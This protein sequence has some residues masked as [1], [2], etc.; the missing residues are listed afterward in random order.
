MDEEANYLKEKQFFL[1]H[2][3]YALFLLCIDDIESLLELNDSLI[4]QTVYS[5]F[6][7]KLIEFYLQLL[8]YLY[9]TEHKI[10]K[11]MYKVKFFSII[12]SISL[13]RNDLNK[14][15]NS[16]LRIIQLSFINFK[17]NNAN[18]FCNQIIENNDMELLIKEIAT[19]SY[20]T[21]FWLSLIYTHLYKLEQVLKLNNENGLQVNLAKNLGIHHEIRRLFVDAIK[22]NSKSLLIW[23]FYMKF[24]ILYGDS[25][26]IIS[27]YYQSIKNL[28]YNKDLYLLAV[29]YLPEK[30]NEIMSLLYNKE[31]RVY[32][33]IQELN[34][35][36]EP[37]KN[38]NE[39]DFIE[40]SESFD[41]SSNESYNSEQIEV[42]SEK[43]GQLSE[44]DMVEEENQVE[45]QDLT[46]SDS[47]SSIE[48]LAK[49]DF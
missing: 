23:M 26:K 40:D 39:Q 48:N 25:N 29:E 1:Y 36:L 47:N 14:S 42:Q 46:D 16:L 37:I 17:S 20:S 45:D 3:I 31:V 13:K 9:F 38:K 4:T 12:R 5:L 7:S 32:L 8:N 33:P 6:R 22:Y 44:I 21:T 30:Y 2:K 34:I 35:L 28:P 27:V 41:E 10:T 11:L 15:Y 43:S 49:I 19:S 24:E 18:L